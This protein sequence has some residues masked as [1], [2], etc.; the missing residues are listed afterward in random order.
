MILSTNQKKWNLT[1]ILHNWIWE[2]EGYPHTP[3][4]GWSQNSAKF[5]N[6][7][8]YKVLFSSFH[9]NGYTIGFHPQTQ[10][11]KPL[12]LQDSIIHSGSEKLIVSW[13]ATFKCRSKDG[14]SQ[15][16]DYCDSDLAFARITWEMP[17]NLGKKTPRENLRKIISG[18]QF[19]FP[20]TWWTVQ[21]P[22]ARNLPSSSSDARIPCLILLPKKAKFTLGGTLEKSA[23]FFKEVDSCTEPLRSKKVFQVQ[24][25]RGKRLFY[26]IFRL[27]NTVWSN[28]RIFL[29]IISAPGN[30]WGRKVI[31]LKLQGELVFPRNVT[32]VTVAVLIS[33]SSKSRFSR[34]QVPNKCSIGNWTES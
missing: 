18:S 24:N 7:T 26:I 8:L 16:T 11:V 30:L 25:T 21:C 19:S 17:L 27:S 2:W 5:P 22:Y 31:P 32:V 20:E 4:G 9:L 6:F 1:L 13:K 23:L 14:H 3:K 29:V 12:Y 33:G 10:K 28:F 34:Q 15:A